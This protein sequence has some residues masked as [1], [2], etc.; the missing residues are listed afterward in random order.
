MIKKLTYPFTPAQVRSL[1]VGERVLLCGR[2]FTGR[3]RLHQY[4]A[5]GRRSPV[6][7]RNGA[8]YHCGPVVVRA[9]GRWNVRAAGPTTSAR[10]EPYMASIIK[11]YGLSL[12]IGK[13]G[14]GASTAQACRD[15]G[16]T[17]LQAVGGAA[18]VLKDTVQ[19]VCGVHLYKAFGPTEALWELEVRDFPCLVTMDA[20]GRNLP[21]QIAKRSET[22]LRKLTR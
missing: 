16:C 22:M 5:A 11:R 13:G 6:S 20:R 21:A 15:Y 18:Q 3:D 12:I 8:I 9:K 17:Y 10:L 7:L 19:K 4:L 2:I 1:K 14:M